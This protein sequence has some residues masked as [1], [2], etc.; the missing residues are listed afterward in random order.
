MQVRVVD[1]RYI[2]KSVHN[3]LLA[4]LKRKRDVMVRKHIVIWRRDGG[5]KEG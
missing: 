3:V 4:A 2:V 5:A 1:V